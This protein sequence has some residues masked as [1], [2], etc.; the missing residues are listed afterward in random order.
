[1]RGLEILWWL[2]YHAVRAALRLQF[3]AQDFMKLRWILRFRDSCQPT[4][5]LVI[6]G[7]HDPRIGGETNGDTE[8]ALCASPKWHRIDSSC[9]GE[10][11]RTQSLQVKAL[12]KD[13]EL[14][15]GAVTELAEHLHINQVGGVHKVLLRTDRRSQTLVADVAAW[16]DPGGLA[17]LYTGNHA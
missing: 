17:K 10:A 8:D 3:A 15:A 1:M 16:V 2:R 9:E 5:R 14:V 7:N 4:A 12:V 6:V 11:S 13:V